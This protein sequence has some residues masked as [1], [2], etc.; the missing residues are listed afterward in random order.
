MVFYYVRVGLDTFVE[1]SSENIFE[2]WDVQL[3]E[4]GVVAAVIALKI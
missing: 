1:Q 3:T 4:T 2:Y